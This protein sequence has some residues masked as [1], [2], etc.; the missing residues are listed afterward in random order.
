MSLTL[1]KARPY[2]Q[3]LQTR[4]GTYASSKRWQFDNYLIFLFS[5]TLGYVNFKAPNFPKDTFG[6]YV[7]FF[8]FF[9]SLFVVVFEL[10]LALFLFL[11]TSARDAAG[12]TEP[13]QWA[14]GA[15]GERFAWILPRNSIVY[16]RNP[17]AK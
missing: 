8:R 6:S 12:Q 1:Q 16:G 3:V 11:K 10:F 13:V 2:L 15:S 5:L 17:T 14:F 9:F 7:F 4:N